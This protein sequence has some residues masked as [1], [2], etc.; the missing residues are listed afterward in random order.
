[1]WNILKD[2]EAFQIHFQRSGRFGKDYEAF[3][4]HF[5]ISGGFFQLL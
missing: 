3:K 2:V 5:Q 1:M 4:I